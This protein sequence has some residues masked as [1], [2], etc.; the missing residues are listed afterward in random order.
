[1]KSNF[2]CVMCLIRAK[3]IFVDKVLPVV[4]LPR[5]WRQYYSSFI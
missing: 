1:M 3:P 5:V 4:F 2:S